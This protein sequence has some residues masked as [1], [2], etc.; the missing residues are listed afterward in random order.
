MCPHTPQIYVYCDILQV[1]ISEHT[2]P[3]LLLEP[4][5][6]M[7]L[8]RGTFHIMLLGFFNLL[9]QCI[10]HLYG[11]QFFG[12]YFGRR[13]PNLSE[14][15]QE[16]LQISEFGHRVHM[17]LYFA[18]SI[19]HIYASLPNNYIIFPIIND[20]HIIDLNGIRRLVITM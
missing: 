15:T 19:M 10:Q 5:I 6:V 20:R 17:D 13:I 11:Y 7:S 4:T 14:R 3:Y 2:Q 12:D 1:A 16:T 9:D 8:F 18:E